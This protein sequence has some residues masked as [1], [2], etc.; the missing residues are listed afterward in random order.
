MTSR[1]RLFADFGFCKGRQTAK[2]EVSD[3]IFVGVNR[4]T[5]GL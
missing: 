3:C 4:R 1:K 5:Y 2:A